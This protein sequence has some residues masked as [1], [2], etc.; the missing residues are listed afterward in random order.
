MA[1]L[2]T[3]GKAG[4]AFVNW[5]CEEAFEE[6]EWVSELTIATQEEEHLVAL[7]QRIDVPCVVQWR[8][9]WFSAPSRLNQGFE[10]NGT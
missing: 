9:P 7:H 6:H 3:M 1:V 4:V 8:M 2:K 10:G 5:V